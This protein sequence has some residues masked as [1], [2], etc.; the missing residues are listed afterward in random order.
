MSRAP[1]R[2]GL[3]KPKQEKMMVQNVMQSNWAPVPQQTERRRGENEGGRNTSACT[4]FHPFSSSQS[5]FSSSV[6]NLLYRARSFLKF[7]KRMVM[8]IADKTQ[9]MTRLL[10]IEYQWTLAGIASFMDK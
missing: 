5:S 7:F 2:A 8:I 10:A 9:T 6:A 3:R 1:R 4:N